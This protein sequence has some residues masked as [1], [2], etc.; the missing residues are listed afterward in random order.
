MPG[1]RVAIISLGCKVNQ[2]EAA[3][4]R[5]G[6][7]TAG[8][9]VVEGKGPA[10]LVVIN[11]CAVTSAAAAQSRQAIRR[12][13]RDNPEAEVVLT[14]CQIELAGREFASQS[15]LQG[16]TLT[17][18]GNRCKDQLVQAALAAVPGKQCLIFGDIAGARKIASLPVQSFAR[19]S[20]ALLR[21]QDGCESFCSYCIVPYTRGPNRS[22]PIAEA[23]AQ[24]EV[25][26]AAGHREIVLTG[27]HL[28]T[29]G[30]D[31]TENTDFRILL[32][33]LSRAT[34]KTSYRISSLEP[35]EISDALLTLI[36]E[37]D[38]IHHHLHIPLQSGE[39]KILARMNRRYSTTQFRQV[40]N[41]CKTVLP[42]AGIGIDIMAGFPGES[43]E[44]F[45]SSYDFI[46]S[47]ECSYLHAFPYSTR[48]GTAAALYPDQLKKT[49]KERR[50]RQLRQLSKTKRRQF[51]QSQLGRSHPVLGEGRRDND[52]LLHG[53]TGN[54]IPVHFPG[55]D[56]R[57]NTISQVRLLHL[58]GD[59]VIGQRLATHED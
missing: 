30:M 37:R 27:I 32:D 29:Y 58:Q 26:A 44:Q 2:Y 48:P 28:G 3:A 55:P 57:L 25:L 1:K 38:N 59:S 14:G 41:R 21:I 7:E 6:F 10:D 20:R 12:A 39:D 17:M 8:L 31:L 52:G 24:A 46:A 33:Q 56:S 16:R 54:Y 11:S 43:E 36:A 49:I 22:L 34:P 53:F 50:V 15:E 23:I 9:E 51:H 35:T 4:F 19:R 47:L 40:I 13:I 5:A 42:D 18:V 45:T